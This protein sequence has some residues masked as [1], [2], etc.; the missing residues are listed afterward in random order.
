ML[1]SNLWKPFQR[2]QQIVNFFCIFMF[3]FQMSRHI[4]QYSSEKELYTTKEKTT[5]ENLSFPLVLK[6]CVN[7]GFNNTALL[8]Y[9]YKDTNDYFTGYAING[10]FVGWTGMQKN[11]TVTGKNC[12]SI[13]IQ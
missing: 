2:S 4:T 12:S 9:G 1:L 13:I 3:V 5:L 11:Y 10:S 7:P 6:V 8:F